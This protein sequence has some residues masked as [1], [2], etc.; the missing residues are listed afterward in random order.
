[1]GPL[2]FNIFINDI[3]YE[4]LNMY[5]YADDNTLAEI[6]K[7]LPD[8][9]TR[10]EKSTEKAMDWFTANS[11]EAN[12]SKFQ[13]L[14]LG[15]AHN[16]ENEI[17]NV[18]NTEIK[19]TSSVKLLGVEVDNDLRFDLH[20][21]TICKKAAIQLNSLR[22]LAPYLDM[23][24]RKLLFNSFIL[25]NFNYCPL[26]WHH[27]STKNT[28]KMEKIQERGLRIILQDYKST[29]NELLQTT[30]RDFLYISRLK[31]MMLFVYKSS[32]HG[33]FSEDPQGYNLCDGNKLSQPLVNTWA[34]PECRCGF[35]VLYQIRRR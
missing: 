7:S 32:L 19:P 30:G 17:F 13:A 2:L 29:Y 21:S 35:C 6:S 25:S 27:C 26:V 20:I 23:N 22:R 4:R 16:K 1:M 31:K 9:I 33:I 10:L 28:L 12:P 11:M 24:T 15:N 8:L 18:N 34:G 3:L 14:I 5:N